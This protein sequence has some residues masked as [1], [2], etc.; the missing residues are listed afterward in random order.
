LGKNILTGNHKNWEFN[1]II[2]RTENA[3]Q[4][5]TH[6]IFNR[7]VDGASIDFQTDFKSNQLQEAG[8]AS[9]KSFNTAN[10]E[11]IYKAN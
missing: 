1:R 7:F 9:R 5:L 11:L 10:M 4:N 2:D 8:N 6:V 3:Y